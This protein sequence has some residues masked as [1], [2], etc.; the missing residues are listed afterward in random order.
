MYRKTISLILSLA[1][2]GLAFNVVPSVSADDAGSITAVYLSSSGNDSNS[3][4]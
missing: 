3:G 2:V 1:L 4:N